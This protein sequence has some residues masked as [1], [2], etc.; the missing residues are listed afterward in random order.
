MNA[1]C[2]TAP[3]KSRRYA[4]LAPMGGALITMC[5]AAL[6]VCFWHDSDVP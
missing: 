5:G 3:T 2:Q 4:S 6:E 1:A